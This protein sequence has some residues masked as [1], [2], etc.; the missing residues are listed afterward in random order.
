M[1]TLHGFLDQVK[2]CLEGCFI[3][4]CVNIDSLQAVPLLIPS[5]VC[6]GNGFDGKGGTQKFL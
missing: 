4:K 1:V 3:R 2:M 6:S 5:P